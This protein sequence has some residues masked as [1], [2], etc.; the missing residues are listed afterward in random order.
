MNL[1]QEVFFRKTIVGSEDFW[2]DLG[3][4]GSIWVNLRKEHF[5]RDHPVSMYSPYSVPSKEQQLK[6]PGDLVLSVFWWF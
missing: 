3:D 6:A 2:G 5:L 1:G 4:E